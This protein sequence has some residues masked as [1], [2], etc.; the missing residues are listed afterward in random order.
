[1]IYVQKLGATEISA[2]LRINK[3]AVYTRKTRLVQRL[4][5]AA[6]R[7]GLTE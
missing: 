6:K 7:A 5:E 1:M 3:G 4:R 2:A